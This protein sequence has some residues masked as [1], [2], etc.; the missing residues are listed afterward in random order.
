M[1]Q[2]GERE[3]EPDRDERGGVG[4]PGGDEEVDADTG[5]DGAEVEGE[6]R[7]EFPFRGEV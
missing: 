5:E 1:P 4:G 6:S 3:T 2:S 7:H